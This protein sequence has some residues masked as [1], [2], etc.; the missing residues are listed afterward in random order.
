[1]TRHLAWLIG[2]AAAFT[3][4]AVLALATDWFR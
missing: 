4:T 2:T 1:M 3:L